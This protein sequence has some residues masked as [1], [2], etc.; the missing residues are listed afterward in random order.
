MAG[1]VEPGGV[2]QALL[3]VIEEVGTLRGTQKTLAAAALVLARELDGGSG[4]SENVARELRITVAELVAVRQGK[5]ATA[6]DSVAL[7]QDEVARKRQ[8][9]EA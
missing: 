8:Q 3:S 6:V 1:E 9:R 4:V 2:E 7:L 5:A